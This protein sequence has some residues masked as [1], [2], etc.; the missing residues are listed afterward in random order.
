[1]YATLSTDDKNEKKKK[2]LVFQKS[3]R[4]IQ[5]GAFTSGWV[6]M[7]LQTFD[8]WMCPRNRVWWTSSDEQRGRRHCSW[9]RCRTFFW[10]ADNA[11]WIPTSLRA[12]RAPSNW[13]L[14]V[15]AGSQ[16]PKYRG[17]VVGTLRVCGCLCA[18]EHRD[19]T[20]LVT[21]TRLHH[22]IEPLSYAVFGRK[23]R[24]GDWARVPV[25]RGFVRQPCLGYVHNQVF[26]P[27]QRFCLCCF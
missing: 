10:R 25:Q 17:K 22:S 12:P 3:G 19:L 24:R 8:L 1:M 13:Q 15:S 2:A 21:E 4:N 26:E 7:T 20:L 16:C 11:A 18:L 9:R 6:K 27:K 14:V 23:C 5:S